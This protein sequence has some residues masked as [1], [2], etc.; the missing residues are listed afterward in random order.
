MN[1]ATRI[2]DDMSTVFYHAELLFRFESQCSLR[3][4]YES[5]GIPLLSERVPWETLGLAYPKKFDNVDQTRKDINDF[6]SLLVVA[7]RYPP[8]MLMEM[9]E[10]WETFFDS[11][12]ET[13]D[14]LSGRGIGFSFQRLLPRGG[15]VDVAAVQGVRR[16]QIRDLVRTAGELEYEGNGPVSFGAHRQT[17]V[18]AET[19]IARERKEAEVLVP[20]VPGRFVIVLRDTEHRLSGMS[21]AEEALPLSLARV[22]RASQSSSGEEEVMVEWWRQQAG[23]P[24]LPFQRALQNRRGQHPWRD[25]ISRSSILLANVELTMSRTLPAQCRRQIVE[26]GHP[27]LADWEYVRGRGLVRK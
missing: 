19:R 10:E 27:S 18:R 7:A 5:P 24:N 14:D 2:T 17:R 11:I 16:R 1:L 15:V 3:T 21:A 13:L 9:E 22:V 25:Q 20:L 4:Y 23:N 8:E 12:P 26:L 6:F